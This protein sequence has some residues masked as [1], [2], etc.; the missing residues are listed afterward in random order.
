MLE[1]REPTIYCI[2]PTG[3]L[4]KPALR[5]GIE[6]FKLGAFYMSCFTRIP[7]TIIHTKVQ[8]LVRKIIVEQSPLSHPP[9]IQNLE[10]EYL[11]FYENPAHRPTVV[12]FRDRMETLYREMD[13]RLEREL[14]E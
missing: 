14:I 3:N 12:Q 2:W 7:V 8:G 6:E 4:W 1:D 5:N 13:D 11:K 9:E 10:E